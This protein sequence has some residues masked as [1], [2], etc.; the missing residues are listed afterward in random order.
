M[1]SKNPAEAG[2]AHSNGYPLGR[3][4]L[5]TAIVAPEARDDKRPA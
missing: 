1:D 2:L 3:N 4:D 5:L